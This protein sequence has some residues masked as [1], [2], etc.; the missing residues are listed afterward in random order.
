MVRKQVKDILKENENEVMYLAMVACVVASS[1]LII[2]F[3]II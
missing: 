3:L 2:L 1:I